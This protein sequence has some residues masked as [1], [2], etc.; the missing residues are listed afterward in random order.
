LLTARAATFA[1]AALVEMV[2]ELVMVLS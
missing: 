2:R 1:L